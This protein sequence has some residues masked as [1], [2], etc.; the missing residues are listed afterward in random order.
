MNKVASGSKSGSKIAKKTAARLF[1]V[2]AVYQ[3]LMQEQTP[4]QVV[5][6]FIEHRF[7]ENVDGEELVTPDSELFTHIVLGVSE[8]QNDIEELIK[9]ARNNDNSDPSKSS[10]DLAIEP[11][12]NSILHCGALE[13]LDP[14]GVDAPIVISDY[15]HVTD[16]FYDQNEKK[17]VNALLDRIKKY[18]ED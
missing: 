2:Q 7:N 1:A 12:L 6:E 10:N 9:T 3:I 14:K 5:K 11:L 18:L 17:L 4:Q 15:L 13:L 16:A 8:R